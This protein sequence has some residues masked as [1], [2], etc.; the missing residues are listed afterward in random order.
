MRISAGGIMKLI[1]KP[2]EIMRL[3]DVSAWLRIHPSTIYRM[4]NEGNLPAFRLGGTWRFSRT[5]LEKWIDR[6]MEGRA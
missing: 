5:A 6:Q 4:A 3:S 2:H 1:N